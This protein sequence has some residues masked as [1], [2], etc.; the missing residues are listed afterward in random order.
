MR[1]SSIFRSFFVFIALCVGLSFAV[2][3]ALGQDVGADVRRVRGWPPRLPQKEG[4]SQA[5][6]GTGTDGPQA[7]PRIRLRMLI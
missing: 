6:P 7:D 5:A 1:A 2:V 3:G 4:R